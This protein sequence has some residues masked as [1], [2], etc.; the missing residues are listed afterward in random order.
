MQSHSN[1]S[2][3]WS[4][5]PR[6]RAIPGATLS[7]SHNPMHPSVCINEEGLRVYAHTTSAK[8][9]DFWTPSLPPPCQCHTH[10]AYQY[11]CLFL[12][13]SHPPPSADI[14]FRCPLRRE[15]KKRDKEKERGHLHRVSG[16]AGER[17]VYCHTFRA[18][19][20]AAAIERDE[21]KV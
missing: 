13:Y 2:V 18:N 21:R 10:A 9:S 4:Y 8:C 5:H 20:T 19:R 14:I 3:K 12:G 15:E 7:A 1:P 6:P 11:C 16:R 17:G